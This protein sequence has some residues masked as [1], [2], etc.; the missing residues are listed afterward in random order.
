MQPRLAPAAVALA[1]VAL[2]GAGVVV[3][4]DLRAD[5]RRERA[6]ARAEER[7][8]R[9]EEQAARAQAEAEQA[10]REAVRPIAE[11]VFDHAQPLVEAEKQFDDDAFGG[12]SAWED[13]STDATAGQA[14]QA[15]RDE[16]AALTPPPSLAA[17]AAKLAAGI[18]LLREAAALYQEL[19][20]DPDDKRD[21]DL[22]GRVALLRYDEG[23]SAVNG[24][25]LDLFPEGARPAVPLREDDDAEP[26]R[27][28]L[29]KGS[30]LLG[31]GRACGRGE[32]RGDALPE[33]GTDAA[34]TRKVSNDTATILREVVRD[35]RAVPKP[36]RD[37]ARLTAEVDAPLAEF[38]RVAESFE[39]LGRVVGT[40]DGAALDRAFAGIDAADVP[41][42]KL[43]RF[44]RGYGSESCA[45]F[46]E[47]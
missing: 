45:T 12:Y 13:V 31:V 33:P 1:A 15:R 2:L 47:P 3:A 35:L 38:V 16:L 11:A 26:A 8:E 32:V 9:A 25:L 34:K 42:G 44:F 18:R 21:L 19:P 10:Y 39:L 6:E 43:S 28:P 36:G 27:R 14:L 29:S 40:P 17:P 5:E 7:R 20:F 30:Y 4:G 46:F 41:A 23:A 22:F 37:A 24:A